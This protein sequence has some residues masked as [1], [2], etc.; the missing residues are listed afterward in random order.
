MHGLLARLEYISKVGIVHECTRY[1]VK[2]KKSNK[3]SIQKNSHEIGAHGMK[4]STK[5]IHVSVL[6]YVYASF[7][8]YTT[9]CL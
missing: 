4:Y 5:T 2:V 1:K 6:F 9:F 7:I 3:F 8:L